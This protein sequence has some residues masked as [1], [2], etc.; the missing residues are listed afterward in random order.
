[1]S[2]YI[3]T[4]RDFNF[5]KQITVGWST[6][7][8]GSSDGYTPDII[9][10]NGG[11]NIIILNEDPAA[12]VQVSFNGTTVHDQFSPTVLKGL[13]Y[14]NRSISFIWFRLVSGGSAVVSVRSW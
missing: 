7:G 4:G 14:S 10:S 13:C 12:I 8:G 1:M 3:K 9:M 11:S 5:Y 6:F 2:G